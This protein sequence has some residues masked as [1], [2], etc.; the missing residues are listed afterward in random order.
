MLRPPQGLMV[1]RFSVG[2]WRTWPS[3][4]IC[5]FHVLAEARCSSRQSAFDGCKLM[6]LPDRARLLGVKRSLSLRRGA[7]L[8]S[9][10][11]LRSSAHS[12]FFRGCELALVRSHVRV[13]KLQ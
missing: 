10:S 1:P 13:P 7:N 2:C 8:V 6:H 9:R 12:F 4:E 3:C 5:F 11:R